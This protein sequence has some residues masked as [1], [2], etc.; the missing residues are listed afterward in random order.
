MADKQNLRAT[1]RALYEAGRQTVKQVAAEIGTSSR[2]V[3]RWAAA[4]GWKRAKITPELTERAHRVAST[5]AEASEKSLD[6]VIED[7]AVAQRAELITRHRTEWRLIGGLINESMKN[8]DIE[9]AKL[10]EVLARSTKLKQ[11]GE[12]R[13][14]GIDSGPDGQ[15]KIQVVIERE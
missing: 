11:D 7:E 3:E 12:R 10:T 9:R 6:Q 15:T 14:Y 2:T 5:L 13:A 4:D 1:A 8:R